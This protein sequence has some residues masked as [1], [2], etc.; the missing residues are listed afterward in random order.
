MGRFRRSIEL[1]KSSWGVIRAHPQLTLLPVI[2]FAATAVIMAS[3]AVPVYLTATVTD[4]QASLSPLGWVLVAVGYLVTTY[5]IVFFNTALVCA[6]NDHFEGR[7]PTL[8]AALSAASKRAGSILPWAIVSATVSLA[9]RAAQERLGFIGQIAVGLVGLAW[10][11]VTFLVLPIIALE[12]LGVGSAIK[13]SAHLFKQTWGENVLANVG[14]G[15]VGFL[16]VLCGLPVLLLLLTGSM[17]LIVLGVVLFV[18]WMAVV[19]VVVSAMTVV[20]QTA[21]YRYASGN[22]TPAA[23][24]NADFEHAFRPKK[25]GV[26]GALTGGA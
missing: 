23:F 11:L 12:G 25:G 3:F 18:A 17:P 5:A 20:F 10:G 1:A 9:L 6:A 7:T 21:L 22:G 2:S 26:R 15:L 14:I 4:E 19:S 16:A 24:A 8:G 13:R